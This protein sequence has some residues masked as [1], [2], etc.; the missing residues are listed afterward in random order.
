MRRAVVLGAR[1]RQGRVVSQPTISVFRPAKCLSSI[2]PL[3]KM[4][5]LTPHAWSGLPVHRFE[6][7]RRLHLAPCQLRSP[8]LAL[9]TAGE[10]TVDV[11]LGSQKHWHFRGHGHGFDLYPEGEYETIAISESPRTMLVLTLSASLTAALLPHAEADLALKHCRFQF[12]DRTLERLVR[13]LASHAQDGEPL[14]ALYTRS[15]SAAVLTR[16]LAIQGTER[17]DVEP[18][19]MSEATRRDLLE[20]IEHQLATPPRV[21]ELALVCGLASAEFVKAFR[22]EFGLTLHQFILDR[23]IAKAK[24]LLSQ[25]TSLTMVALELGFANHGHFTATFHARTGMTPSEYRRRIR[26]PADRRA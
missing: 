4:V 21:D 24:Q 18:Q 22:R 8:L 11:R 9:W 2:K 23:R 16:L 19:G 3:P 12:A 14:G 15:L 7:A 25:E 13:A 17:T 10:A 5:S 26:E 1:G 20:L 6:T